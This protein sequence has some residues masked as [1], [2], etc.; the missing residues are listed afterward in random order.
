MPVSPRNR[1]LNFRLTE[2][3]YDEVKRAAA[4]EGSRCVSDFARN[5]L[6]RHSRSDAGFSIEKMF[7]NLEQ[8]ICALDSRIYSLF[9]VAQRHSGGSGA[10]AIGAHEASAES[11]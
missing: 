4:E 10:N 7:R 11:L 5:A 8:R 9:Y 2:Q 1:V 6:L 3:E